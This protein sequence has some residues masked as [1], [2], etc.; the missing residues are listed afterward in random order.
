MER[1]LVP[2]DLGVQRFLDADPPLDASL[3]PLNLGHDFLNILEFIAPLPKNGLNIKDVLYDRDD[4]LLKEEPVITF[5][6]I[7]R[8]GKKGIY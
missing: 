4:V 2:R 7:G 3:P 8:G 6:E 1:G 5:L